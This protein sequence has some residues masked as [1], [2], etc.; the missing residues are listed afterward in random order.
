MIPVVGSDFILV[1]GVLSIGDHHLVGGKDEVPIGMIGKHQLLYGEV[2]GH[3]H[4]IGGLAQFGHLA[5]RGAAPPTFGLHRYIGV[6]RRKGF[7]CL[8]E[9][10]R[11]AAGVKDGE[12]LPAT[13]ADDSQQ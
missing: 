10:H 13:A 1:F 7:A 8:I 6:L 2:I 9:G 5:Y 4:H 11:Q 3:S 12:R